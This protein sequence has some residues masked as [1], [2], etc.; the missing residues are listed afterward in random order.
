MRAGWVAW[1]S[2]GCSVAAKACGRA[3]V[4]A[5]GRALNLTQAP[6]R[7]SCDTL[8][9]NTSQAVRISWKG[10][11]GQQC[12]WKTPSTSEWHA[13]PCMVFNPCRTYNPEEGRGR[14]NPATPE[15]AMAELLSVRLL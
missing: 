9:V 13:T 8:L 15:Q 6:S 2:S 7:L 10:R 4:S 1:F 14:K 5:T 11:H 12:R 3:A